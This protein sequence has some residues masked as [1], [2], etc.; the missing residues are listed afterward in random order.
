MIHLGQGVAIG[1]FRAYCC[2]LV[3]LSE[4]KILAVEVILV[5]QLVSE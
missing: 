4:F 5:D 2:S 1:W 3:S